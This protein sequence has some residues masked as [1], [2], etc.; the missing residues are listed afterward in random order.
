[1]VLM[2]RAGSAGPSAGTSLPG[3]SIWAAG[4]GA[5]GPESCPLLSAKEPLRLRS[6]E[7]SRSKESIQSRGT[8]C[9][10]ERRE[11]MW[12]Y[13]EITCDL[14]KRFSKQGYRSLVMIEETRNAIAKTNNHMSSSFQGNRTGCQAVAIID[15]SLLKQCLISEEDQGRWLT[16][17]CSEEEV[18]WA[19]GR[20]LATAIQR[21]AR[22]GWPLGG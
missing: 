17:T 10:S 9:C 16:Q 5:G 22:T 11:C 8:A 19:G 20:S 21:L 4:D 1:M 2:C 7:S 15:Q 18:L 14:F 12:S 3:F 13:I 6:S